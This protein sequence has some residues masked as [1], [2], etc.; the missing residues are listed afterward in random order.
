LAANGSPGWFAGVV[1]V[2]ETNGAS[3]TIAVDSGVFGFGMVGNGIGSAGQTATILEGVGGQVDVNAAAM[4]NPLTAALYAH[5]PILTGSSSHNYGLFIA[6]Q[7]VGGAN[8]PDPWG[9]FESGT[10]KN[11]FGGVLNGAAGFQQNGTPIGIQCGTTTTCANTAA[12]LTRVVYGQV[13]LASGTPSTAVVTGISPA[14]TSANTF[15]CSA[16]NASVAADNVS[17]SKTSTS[18]I[19]ITGPATV[20]DLILYLCVGT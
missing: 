12:P 8:N 16:D 6:D 20:T 17:I 15:E 9:I 18:S 10:A 19:T 7:T 1:G 4:T 2:T 3:G 11:Q 13:N 5:S 14:F